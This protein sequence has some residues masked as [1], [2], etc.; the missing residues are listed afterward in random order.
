[1][2]FLLRNGIKE[3]YLFGIIGGHQEMNL[4]LLFKDIMVLTSLN[5]TNDLIWNLGRH[6]I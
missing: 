3:V 1:M 4:G 5:N 2:V 6:K